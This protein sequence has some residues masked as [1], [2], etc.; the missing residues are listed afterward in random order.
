LTPRIKK[1]NHVASVWISARYPAALGIVAKRAGEPEIRL[2]SLAPEGL[3]DEV[4][5]FHTRTDDRF[6]SQAVAAP[7]AG[8]GCD[9]GPVARSKYK[10]GSFDAGVDRHVESAFF[11]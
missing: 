11:Q 6:L 3:R 5:Q 1:A 7:M 2:F 10:R 9:P 4:I 8:L